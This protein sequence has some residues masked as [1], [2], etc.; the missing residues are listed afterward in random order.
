MGSPVHKTQNVQKNYLNTRTLAEHLEIIGFCRNGR[1]RVFEKQWNSELNK[2]RIHIHSCVLIETELFSQRHLAADSPVQPHRAYIII[3]HC[4][5]R[6]LS[7]FPFR[8]PP[9]LGRPCIHK[10]AQLIAPSIM[11][12]VQTSIDDIHNYPGDLVPT[13]FRRWKHLTAYQMLR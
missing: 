8:C 11:A 5:L 3:S 7:Y 13:N 12:M 9:L 4:N 6:F 1:A 2:L 10:P